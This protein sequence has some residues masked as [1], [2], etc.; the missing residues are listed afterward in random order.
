[1]CKG[2]QAVINQKQ[3]LTLYV[4]CGVHCVNL[5]AQTVTEA[6]VPV[7]DAVHS[8]NELG[9][10]F[11]QSIK[12]RTAFQKSVDTDH[13]MK[14]TETNQTMCPTRW[15]VRVPAIVALIDQYAAIL[16]CLEEMS[17]DKSGSNVVARVSG[18]VTV[19]SASSTQL[20]LKMAL[21]IL[22]PLAMLNKSLQSRYQTVAG[23]CSAVEEIIETLI[24]F[25]TEE[26]FDQLLKDA[27]AVSLNLD[28]TALV[29]PRHQRDL[30]KRF[31]GAAIAHVAATVNEYFR[32]IFF[33]LIDTAVQQ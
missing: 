25:R 14:K 2:C 24:A 23:M 11:S 8:L 13:D 33:V 20:C 27:N 10:L 15:L 12:C 9:A 16:Q 32:R 22:G 21:Q 29:A 19:F 7:R 1:L 18:L 31:T 30:P 17:T 28:L 4:H 5:V 26:D 6:V 3:P